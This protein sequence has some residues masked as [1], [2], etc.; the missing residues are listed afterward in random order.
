MKAPLS[1]FYFCCDDCCVVMIRL[2]TDISVRR[3]L[4]LMRIL[5][6]SALTLKQ[7]VVI[8]NSTAERVIVY[9]TFIYMSI[10]IFL[11]C[12]LS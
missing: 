5:V 7:M 11:F 8:F 3:Q 10:D 12:F 2:R 1:S 4:M 6:L 9:S